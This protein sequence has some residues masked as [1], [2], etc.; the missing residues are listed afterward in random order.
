MEWDY[1]SFNYATRQYEYFGKPKDLT[2]EQLELKL[3]PPLLQKPPKRES[4]A[5]D[6]CQCASC[7]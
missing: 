7:R 2:E 5:S 1:Q 6:E 3:D 4:L